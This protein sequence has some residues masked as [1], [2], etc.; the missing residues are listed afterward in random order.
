MLEVAVAPVV[1]GVDKEG[2]EVQIR[3]SF[4]TFFDHL[5]RVALAAPDAIFATLGWAVFAV[6]ATEAQAK[7]RKRVFIGADTAEFFAP[8][9]AGRVEAAGVEGRLVGEHWPG[10]GDFVVVS[11]EEFAVRAEL[12]VAGGDGTAAG[13]DHT[14]D[15]GAQRGL[16]DIGGALNI[17]A[18]DGLAVV[19]DM[20]GEVDDGVDFFEGR[21][22]RFEV[23][24]IGAVAVDLG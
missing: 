14:A 13:E 22:D 12:G 1:V 24:N 16:E 8:Y 9:F 10:C 3:W 23:G 15:P 2:V 20:G 21:L 7:D 6:N 5:H 19:A 18:L 17:G 11:R 4:D